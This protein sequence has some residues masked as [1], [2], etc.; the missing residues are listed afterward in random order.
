MWQGQRLV[1]TED[2]S[3]CEMTSRRKSQGEAWV[4]IEEKV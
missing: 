4:G 2:G 1:G 3:R